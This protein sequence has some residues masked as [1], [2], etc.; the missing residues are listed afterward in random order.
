MTNHNSSPAFAALH[1]Q[2]DAYAREVL[3]TDYATLEIDPEHRR[4]VD[5]NDVRDPQEN[6][7]AVP[8][9]HIVPGAFS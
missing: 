5:Y 7:V 8:D 4:M 9:F 1:E 2:I 6:V 3:G